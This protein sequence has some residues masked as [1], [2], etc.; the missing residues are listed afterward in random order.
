MKVFC[1]GCGAKIDVQPAP[2]DT[3]V[4]C[5]RCHSTFS[6]EGIKAA[7]AD[8]APRPA[9]R[10]KKKPGGRFVGALI[11]VV[12]LLVLG[13][14]TAAV[15]YFTGVFRPLHTE[16]T[17]TASNSA[18]TGG[19]GSVAVPENWKPFE[20][21][22]AKF[23]ALFPGSP[24]RDPRTAHLSSGTRVRDVAFELE[25][26]GV[27]YGVV[28]ADMDQRGLR[29]LT[30][31]QY[32]DQQRQALASSGKLQSEKDVTVGPYKGKEFV[33]DAPGQGKAFMRYFAAGRRLYSLVVKGKSRAPEPNEVAKF[34]DSFRITD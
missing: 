24:R 26:G 10:K 8:P 4:Q 32:I 15:L 11:F 30:P 19:T 29:S 34:F 31:E 2:G 1:P 9:F 13:G 12:V 14:G 3:D 18:K 17:S 22:E 20:S 28:Y 7:P 25:E 27:A 5:P 23:A 16:A 21:S 33:I 6:T